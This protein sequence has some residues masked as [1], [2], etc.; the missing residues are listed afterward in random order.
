MWPGALKRALL[1]VAC[2]AVA[3]T[4]AGCESTESESARI[5]REAAV[6]REHEPGALKLGA[7]SR[8]VR[9]ARV[10]LLSGAGRGAV[11]IEL[12]SSSAHAQAEV[13]VLVDVKGTSGRLLYSNQPGGTDPKLQRA[14]LVQ[15]RS[16]TWWVN[17]Q[18]LLNQPSTG[19][20]V[21]VGTGR[22]LAHVPRQ[23]AARMSSVE[24]QGAASAVLGQVTNESSSPQ[25]DVAVYAVAL[26]GEKVVAAG[27]G[28]IAELP[29]RRGASASFRVP[30]V[31]DP[32]KAKVELT[33]VAPPRGGS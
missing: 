6:A 2:G 1:V 30:L 10:T 4:L 28:Q 29:G 26:Q 24:R 5:D 16:S 27:R 17:D 8:D 23:L 11:A 14:P 31:G 15:P 21:R 7:T 20:T 25:R 13:P 12:R 19:V 3:A 9:A 18:V 22:T 32:A 33:A